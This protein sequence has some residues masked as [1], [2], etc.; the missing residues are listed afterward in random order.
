MY[1]PFCGEKHPK[2][3]RFCPNSGNTMPVEQN[4]PK[5][6]YIGLAS[7]SALFVIFSSYKLLS[8]ELSNTTPISTIIPTPSPSPTHKI[9][10]SPSSASRHPSSTPIPIVKPVDLKINSKDGVEIVF[11]PGG[12]FLMGSKQEHDPFFWGAEAPEHTVT[13][14]SFWIYRTEV[15]Q[16]MYKKCV[17]EDACPVP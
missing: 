8:E 9:I 13:L 1:C 15:T 7:I 5:I 11:V 2:G 4:T 10:T 6:F 17:D 14:D 16:G 3:T 12:E